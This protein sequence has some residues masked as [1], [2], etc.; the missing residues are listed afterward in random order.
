MPLPLCE[1]S[2]CA[3]PNQHPMAVQCREKEKKICNCRL[4]ILQRS[5][6]SRSRSSPREPLMRFQES[7]RVPRLK[8]GKPHSPPAPRGCSGAFPSPAPPAHPFLNSQPNIFPARSL[9]KAFHRQPRRNSMCREGRRFQ[10]KQTGKGS[11]QMVKQRKG[12]RREK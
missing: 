10:E 6:S 9:G 1:Q 11:K 5:L 7:G 2:A 4:V 12:E 8:A 3:R